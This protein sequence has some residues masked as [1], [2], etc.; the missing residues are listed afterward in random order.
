MKYFLVLIFI[1]ISGII[2][3]CSSISK[4][5]CQKA[6]WL[7]KGKSDALRGFSEPRHERY[8]K[9]CSEHGLGVDSKKYISGYNT[10]LKL[11]CTYRNG[12][13]LGKKGYGSHPYCEKT[14]SDFKKGLADARA[15]IKKAKAMKEER[16]R[17]R[18]QLLTL[19]NGQVCP[20]DGICRTEGKCLV[21]NRC[22]GTD[23]YCTF[24][25]DCQKKTG[26]ISVTGYTPSQELV[27]VKMCKARF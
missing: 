24:S 5:D 25:S 8:R 20:P 2:T 19:N 12:Y 15:E 14:S 27:T 16:K 22:E 18:A 3:G 4:E 9:D 11:Y 7:E 21:N 17:L 26:C 23:E 13:K 1:M 10:G 6:N